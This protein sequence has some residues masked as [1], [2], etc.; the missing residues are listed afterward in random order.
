VEFVKN[1]R[2]RLQAEGVTIAP[3]EEIV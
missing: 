3:I 1:I 2:E